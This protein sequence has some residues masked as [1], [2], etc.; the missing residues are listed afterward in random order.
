MSKGD[1][2]LRVPTV[3]EAATQLVPDVEKMQS[4]YELA[5][6]CRDWDKALTRLGFERKEEGGGGLCLYYACRN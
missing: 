3:A 6:D 1:Q 5:F 4:P 2:S